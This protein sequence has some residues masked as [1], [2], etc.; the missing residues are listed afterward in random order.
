MEL[1]GAAASN[2]ESRWAESLGIN[3]IGA[4]GD[5]RVGGFNMGAQRRGHQINVW[6]EMVRQHRGYSDSPYERLGEISESLFAPERGA[7]GGSWM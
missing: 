5:V 7:D 4:Q 2:S 6:P 1:R 3:S